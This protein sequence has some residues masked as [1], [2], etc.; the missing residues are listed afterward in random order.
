[1]RT[2]YADR[3]RTGLRESAREAA[4]K[5]ATEGEITKLLADES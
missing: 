5:G 4:E 1:M 3:L 2:F